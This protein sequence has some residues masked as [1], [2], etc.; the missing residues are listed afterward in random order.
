MDVVTDSIFS[1]GFFFDL[2]AGRQESVKPRDE[3]RVTFE[4]LRDSIDHTGGVDAI[5]K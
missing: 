3:K 2:V 1:S 4:K 5:V